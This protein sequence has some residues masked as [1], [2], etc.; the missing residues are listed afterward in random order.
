MMFRFFMFVVFVMF[1]MMFRLFV[2][3]MFR[4]FARGVQAQFQSDFLGAVRFVEVQQT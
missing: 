1:F 2:L 4:F 3:V